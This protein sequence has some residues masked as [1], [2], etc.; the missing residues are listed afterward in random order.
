MEAIFD[1]LLG[2]F[3]IL[4]YSFSIVPIDY[5]F[6]DNY[7]WVYNNYLFDKFLESEI[8]GTKAYVLLSSYLCGKGDFSQEMNNTLKNLVKN[9]TN[10]ILYSSFNG[11]ELWLYNTQKTV[12]LERLILNRFNI[13][14]VC[15][16]AEILFGIWDKNE[17]APEVC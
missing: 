10:F 7:M 12:C 5:R 1:L 15:G 17:K 3:V 11:K 13:T 9:S 16:N 6:E 2:S 14:L 8:N 4:L